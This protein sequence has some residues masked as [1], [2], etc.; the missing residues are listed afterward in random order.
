MGRPP[1]FGTRMSDAE[2][3]RLRRHGVE[4][5][6]DAERQSPPTV[7]VSSPHEPAMIE[8]L[9]QERDQAYQQALSFERE[10]NAARRELEVVA[11][12]RPCPKRHAE[13]GSGRRPHKSVLVLILR[14]AVGRPAR[15]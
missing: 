12:Q 6:R 11:E 2:R 5:A 8:E 14:Q 4:P 7:P 9:K 1:K 13:A 3:Q 10:R 15:S